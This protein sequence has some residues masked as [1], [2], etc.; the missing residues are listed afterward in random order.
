[1]KEFII[2]PNEANQRLDKYLKK[3]LPNASFGFL[4]KMLRK[5]NIVYN[6]QKASGKEILQSG[7]CVRLYFKDETFAQFHTNEVQILQ[8]YEALSQLPMKGLGIVYENEAFLAADKPVGMLSQKAQAS[9]LSANEY[10]LGYLIRS[11]ALPP[12]TFSTFRPSV[13]N[14][15]DRNTTGLLVMGKTLSGA[16]KLSE[17]FRE[18]TVRKDYRAIVSGYVSEPSHLSGFLLK[19]EKTN[20]V[21][22]V[23]KPLPDAAPVETAY[24]PLA[25]GKDCTLLEIHLITG[26]SHQIRAHLSLCGHPIIGDPK[27]G[28][29]EQNRRFREQFGVRFQLLHAYRL[30]FPDRTVVCAPMPESFG[31]IISDL[32][33]E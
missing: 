1:M 9:D 2:Q 25:Y 8:E 21:R 16:Q 20:R 32:Q 31:R 4:Y 29:R 15:L 22:I 28:D 11:G 33:K 19:D 17:M 13:V 6:G 7:G 23:S 3:L 18:R 27:Y 5:K 30:T 10:L 12:E 26:K 24:R 14:R